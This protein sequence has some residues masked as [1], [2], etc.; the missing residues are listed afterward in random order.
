MAITS[1]LF[2]K[3]TSVLGSTELGFVELDCTLESQ[4][5]LTAEPTENPVEFGADVADHVRQNPDEV[6][7]TGIITNTPVEFL[8]GL[9]EPPDRAE[10]A[11]ANL[12]ELKESGRPIDVVMRM[13]TLESMVIKRLSIPDNPG[14]GEAVQ[15][16]IAL[17]HVRTVKSGV[18]P[19]PTT[20]VAAPV[21][22]LGKKPTAVAPAGAAA[23]LESVLSE[24]IP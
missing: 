9:R 17:K 1:L 22:A 16:T 7:L 6:T 14:I 23:G 12:R 3:G 2:Y 24:M 13:S 20:P 15:V 8:A 4:L 21:K 10:S 11:L 5:E 18:A 19:E